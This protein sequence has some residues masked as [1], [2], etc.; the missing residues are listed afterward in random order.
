MA[1]GPVRIRLRTS[2]I[3]VYQRITYACCMTA[4][5]CHSSRLAHLRAGLPEE[6]PGFGRFDRPACGH[7]GTGRTGF[8]KGRRT[9][10]LVT[11][12]LFLDEVL[13]ARPGL[14][15]GTRFADRCNHSATWPQ[16]RPKPP[17]CIERGVSASVQ[18]ARRTESWR[19]GSED[20]PVAA[21]A[22]PASTALA[23][24]GSRALERQSAQTR[25]AFAIYARAPKRFHFSPKMP[26][27]RPFAILVEPIHARLC[28]GPPH[29][30]RQPGAHQRR[31]GSAHHRRDEIPTRAL[32]A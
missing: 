20:A 29:D 23:G 18:R 16:G 9:A 3:L 11:F 26:M 27:E 30:G 1:M 15:R 5:H 6:G 28:R 22:C 10:A 8:D 2:Y 17:I 13:E 32:R 31:H 12:P 19:A 7:R 21:M 24:R 4:I 25:P 14:N